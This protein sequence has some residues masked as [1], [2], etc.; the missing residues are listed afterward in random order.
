MHDPR[1]GRFFA[2][3]PLTKKYPYL[4][5]YQFSSNQ[6][7]HAR[8][9]EGLE[10]EYELGGADG[11][12]MTAEII[13]GAWAGFN[14]LFLQTT[15]FP[16]SNMEG[17]MIRSYLSRHGAE[18]P[19]GVSDRWLQDNLKYR[20]DYFTKVVEPREGALGEA[21][22]FVG[23]II[24]IVGVAPGKGE[25]VTLV[26]APVVLNSVSKTVK[27]HGNF[28]KR[29]FKDLS[30]M[31]ERAWYKYQNQINGKGG[32]NEFRVSWGKNKVDFDGFKNGI[33]L[34]A[35]GYYQWLIKSGMVGSYQIYSGMMKQFKR[36]V[37]AADGIKLEWHFAE[38][39]TMKEFKRYLKRNN[40][41][42][43]D[44][45]EFIYTPAKK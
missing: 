44:N 42:I 29:N 19:E 30:K 15:L 4:T 37:E 43:P 18:V 33:L 40:E 6:P 7:I 21:L 8:E 32:D 2:V 16:G 20:W 9:L 12:M 10:S 1:I 13:G 38:E 14:N 45:V 25:V 41:D 39:S 11:A 31:Q 34:E 3:D 5:P 24:N 17:G 26:K 27:R 35:K 28:W 22:N 36:Q 23:D